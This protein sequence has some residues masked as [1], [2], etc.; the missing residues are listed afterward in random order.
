MKKHIL[1]TA[2]VLFMI[3]TCH[4]QYDSSSVPKV[5]LNLGQQYLE[6]GKRQAKK[7]LI[8][9]GSGIVLNAIAIA[10]YPKD[11]DFIFGGNSSGAE[12]QAILSTTLFITGTSLLITSIPVFITGMI[13]KHKGKVLLSTEKIA[14]TPRINTSSWQLKTGLVFNF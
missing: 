6:K 12:T 4:A 14:L 9:A 11:Y 1:A 7:A 10:A 5:N 8:L 13:N 3:G 2:F